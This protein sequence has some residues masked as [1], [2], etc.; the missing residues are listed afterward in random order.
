MENRKVDKD[1]GQ[2]CDQPI[3]SVK[4]TAKGLLVGDEYGYLSLISSRDGK[5]IRL[6]GQVHDSMIT[7]LIITADQKFFFAASASGKL[8]QWNYQD[9]TL[10][11]DY[12][13][14]TNY[15]FC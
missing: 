12:G 1:F 4:I 9:N 13:K 7:G 15:I 5:V 11:R 8:K 2:V 3:I 10:V 14:I 6:F